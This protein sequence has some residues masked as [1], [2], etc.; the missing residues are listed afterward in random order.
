MLANMYVD[1]STQK[2]FMPATPGCSEHHL[3][4]L[5]ILND[6][7]RKHRSLAV[8]WVDLAN[9]YGSVHHSLIQFSLNHYHAPSKLSKLVK[10]L[11]TGLVAQV[12]SATW[13]TPL[14]PI[15]LGVYQGDPLSVVIFNTVIN[16]LVDTLHTRRDLG[17]HFSPRQLPVNLL[18]YADDT[19]LVAN[20]PA[21]CQHLLD[22]T[23]LWL[24]WSGMKVKISKCAALDLKA[25]SGKK[26]DPLISLQ[27][28]HIPFAS[29]R[30]QF[31]GL[32]VDTPQDSSRLRAELL[33]NVL[34]RVDSCP[35]TSK[36]KLLV[37]R[38]GVCPCISWDLTVVEFPISW[39]QRNLDSQ[40]TRY[41][42][43]WSGLTR[44]A[45]P[46]LLFLSG[47]NGGLNLPLPSTMHKRLQSSHQSHLLTSPDPCVQCMAEE[48][49]KK[50]LTLTRPSFRASCEVR[51]V[52]SHNPDFSKKNLKATT[53]AAV[54]EEDEDHLLNSQGHK[55][56]CSSSDGVKLWAKALGGIDDS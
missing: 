20:S 7:K 12:S 27:S 21:S 14:I 9:A 29:H 30:V 39:V 15:K 33:N 35:L 49:L 43:S 23:A 46:A 56:G 55:S 45:N 11:Y 13:S 28:D 51:T 48:A 19:C 8:C 5:S 16:T 22:M 25:L 37:Y 52:V 26:T 2:A 54:T 34:D 53:K 44:S 42:K 10:S 24:Q 32:H 17:Y 41:L 1:R 18:Q 38:S 40:A 4:L 3:K 47:K 31:L 36:Q 50:D 6:A